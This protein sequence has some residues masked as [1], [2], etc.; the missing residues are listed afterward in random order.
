MVV[1][2]QV[3]LQVGPSLI[4]ARLLPPYLVLV[5]G[6]IHGGRLPRVH[7]IVYLRLVQLPV[8]WRVGVLL[9]LYVPCEP[10]CLQPLLLLL[11]PGILLHLHL[12]HPISIHCDIIVIHLSLQYILLRTDPGDHGILRI[13][14]VLPGIQVVLVH[15]LLHTRHVPIH[16]HLVLLLL[17]LI[18]LLPVSVLYLLPA[19]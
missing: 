8:R 15:L 1:F 17:L 3:H 11:I 6:V 19:H 7:L 12:R 4:V 10:I 14:V 13:I 9:L 5:Q 2:A 18:Q 16:L